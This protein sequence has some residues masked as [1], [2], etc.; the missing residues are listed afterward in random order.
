MCW[1]GFIKSMKFWF[2]KWKV[3]FLQVESVDLAL[4]LLDGSE[5]RGSKIHVEKAKFTMK[6]EFDPSKKRKKLTNKE[7][8]K[9]KEKQQK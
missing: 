8:K 6:G 4:K 1:Q 2:E 3:I 5:L 9:M 7:K